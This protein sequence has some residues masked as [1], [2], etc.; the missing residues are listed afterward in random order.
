M[1]TDSKG[2]RRGE[3]HQPI[4]HHRGELLCRVD[5]TRADTDQ[6]AGDSETIADPVAHL[7]K[8]DP[9]LLLNQLSQADV[10]RAILPEPCSRPYGDRIPSPL[11]KSGAPC[12]RQICDARADPACIQ[13]LE[14]RGDL[15]PANATAILCQVD[16]GRLASQE[17]P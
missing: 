16:V 12:V 5:P 10:S 8:K 2:L 14:M 4:L 7:G 13:M 3:C 9:W 6:A 17:A 1:I 15:N 11:A